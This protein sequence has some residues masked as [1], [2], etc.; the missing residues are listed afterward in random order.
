MQQLVHMKHG[1][2]LSTCRFRPA[3][4][5]IPDRKQ[6]RK[7]FSQLLSSTNGKA[8]NDTH[9]CLE[10]TILFGRICSTDYR[11]MGF[12][13]FFHHIRTD[14]HVH[15]MD[16]FFFLKDCKITSCI[17]LAKSVHNALRPDSSNILS[18]EMS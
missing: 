8:S 10:S 18:N 9:K 15:F 7:G 6:K 4:T 17:N 11:T 3:G 2:P 14:I 13:K 16:F 5:R 1:V 12:F